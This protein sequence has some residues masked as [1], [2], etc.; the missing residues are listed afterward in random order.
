MRTLSASR[1]QL[2]R[3]EAAR[4]QTQHQLEVIDRQIT[5]AMTAFLPRLGRR[6]SGYR[7]GKAS[8]P[9]AFLERYRAYLAA[10]TAERQ[11]DVDALL[12][13]L[14]RQDAII[15]GMRTT[16]ARSAERRGARRAKL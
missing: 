14:A 7:H 15:L 3:M 6:Q 11:P 13:E 9:G 10:L 16:E 12:R 1:A 4:R 8:V 5:R 2:L